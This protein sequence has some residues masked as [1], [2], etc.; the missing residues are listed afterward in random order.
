M[1]M[2]TTKSCEERRRRRN[3]RRLHQ[4]SGGAV[5]SVAGA[6][7]ATAEGEAEVKDADEADVTVA[8]QC[9]RRHKQ[10]GISPEEVMKAVL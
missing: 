1:V 9:N 5:N 2:E 3:H 8:A 10:R 6:K 7:L 4:D